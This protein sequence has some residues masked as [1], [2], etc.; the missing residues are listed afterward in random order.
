MAFELDSFSDAPAEKSVATAGTYSDDFSERWQESTSVFKLEDERIQASIS[1]PSLEL[2][3]DP[4]TVKSSFPTAGDGKP[5]A[6]VKSESKEGSEG[7]KKPGERVG[8]T[9]V[10]RP[11][12][13]GKV[14]DAGVRIGHT[15]IEEPSLSNEDTGGVKPLSPSE[16]KERSEALFDKIDTN[17]DGFLST[18]ELGTAV[19]S[20]QYK[21]E[22]A[23]VVAALF[24]NREKLQELSND[25]WG[26]ENDGV[27]R[28]DLE[29]F[30]AQETVV[31][32]DK[33]GSIDAKL[34]ME[35]GDNFKNADADGDGFLSVKEIDGALAATK[36]ENDKRGLQYLK[37][38]FDKV[39]SSSNDELGFENDGIT[40]KDIKQNAVDVRGTDEAKLVR[41]VERDMDRVAENQEGRV[42]RDLYSDK[43]NPV[44]SITPD[45]VRQGKVGDC[46][47]EG[48]LAA[49]AQKHPE[50]IQKMIKDNGDGT[51][52]VTFPGDP[53][54]P[55][56]VPAPTDAELGLYNGGSEHGT[57]ACVIEKAYGKYLEEQKGVDNAGK[58]HQ[59]A[60]D[61][62]G[63]E[64]DALKLL[65]GKDAKDVHFKPEDEEKIRQEL[66]NAV[67]SG[68]AICTSAT[69]TNGDKLTGSDED[70]PDG[71]SKSHTYT[72][73]GFDPE[74]PD[75]GTVVI[76]NPHG[77]EDG[78][79]EGTIK[80]SMKQYMKNFNHIA[81]EGDK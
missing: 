60:A 68:K 38:N 62:G 53:K 73:I 37:D 54:H 27:T 22:D 25:E 80:I 70:T 6:P 55:I 19:K 36:N 65:T 7:E 47:F 63:L 3:F 41:G 69:E 33:G 14:D 43:D 45:A 18:E 42:N 15:V 5:L 40:A 50:L 39:E 30:D 32:K 29:Q 76:R 31:E 74:G 58:P 17:H 21:G 4:D 56:T 49:V 77:G 8:V 72:V 13:D 64:S 71:F 20:G 9:T 66:I 24:D 46:Y 16:F 48:S 1:L 61:G 28:K 52:T 11:G 59:E 35:S 75:G 2:Y 57:W 81:V 67:K 10:D 23:Q 51:Y 12:E 79:K 26:F 34:W 44:N 78:T